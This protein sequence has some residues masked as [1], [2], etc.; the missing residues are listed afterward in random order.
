M[1]VPLLVLA[2]FLAPAR[3][4]EPAFPSPA[5][6]L[7]RA[8][9]GVCGEPAP[10][11]AETDAPPQGIGLG[12]RVEATP[13]I[14]RDPARMAALSEQFFDAYATESGMGRVEYVLAKRKF[15]AVQQWNTPFLQSHFNSA[16]LH[17]EKLEVDGQE[18][19][20]MVSDTEYNGRKIS[21]HRFRDGISS[22]SRVIVD[23]EEAKDDNG[24]PQRFVTK[25]KAEFDAFVKW[26]EG[27]LGPPAARN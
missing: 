8:C 10:P 26:F 4:A 9:E 13:E 14:I 16:T 11:A 19:V 17:L 22:V 7:Q 2:S 5:Q 12:T 20:V 25:G 24:R 6:V 27:R 15:Q 3:A 23:G 18:R 1:P 21:F